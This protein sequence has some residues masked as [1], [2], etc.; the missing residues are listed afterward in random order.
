MPWLIFLSLCFAT[1][2]ANS[3]DQK[4]P[5]AHLLEIEIAAYQLSSAFSAYVQFNGDPKFS[6]QLETTISAN[7]EVF[8]TAKE[9]YPSIFKKWQ[10]SLKF[11]DNS[12]ALVFDGADHRLVTGHAIHQNQLYKLIKAAQLNANTNTPNSTPNQYEYLVTRAAFERVIAQ[13]ISFTGSATGFIHSDISIEE[14]VNA[15]SSRLDKIPSENASYQ[16]L[17][18]KWNFIKGNMT[19]STSRTTP[20]ITL[21]TAADI[22]KTL[23]RIYQ[24]TLVTESDF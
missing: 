14:S 22:R 11:I 7:H 20:F 19:V 8:N 5:I 1:F 10:Q 9:S 6:R 18:K 16:R 3:Q 4:P 23:R 12:K 13:Y 2:N 24:N 21:H 17:N 15:F